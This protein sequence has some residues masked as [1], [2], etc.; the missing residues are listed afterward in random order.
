MSETLGRIAGFEFVGL[1][2][3]AMWTAG[4]VAALLIVVCYF[5][6]SHAGRADR[7]GVAARVALILVGA[8]AAFLAIEAWSRLDLRSERRELDARA[9]ELFMR[10]ATPG[11]AFACLDP[12]VGDVVESACEKAV[13]QSPEATAA[14]LS[15]VAAELTLLA[16]FTVYARKVG[17][18]PPLALGNLRRSIEGDRFGLVARVLAVRDGCTPGNC[19]AFAMLTDPGRIAV[20]LAGRSYD[21]YVER[22]AAAWPAGAKSPVVAATGAGEGDAPPPAAST[23]RSGL[24]F[25]SA[26]SIPPVTIM[27]AEPPLP[28]ETTGSTPPSTP[29]SAAPKQAPARRPAASA[30]APANSGNAQ[31]SRP[32]I[33]LNAAGR[34]SPPASAPQ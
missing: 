10:A 26:A 18:D 24:F 11:S 20:N 22:H 28:P 3:L 12:L 15:Y 4:V 14:A 34:T 19:P 31:P 32:P 13:F 7:I 2:S 6:F 16:D 33:D 8:V 17:S 27:N 9:Q 21:L 30:G 5:S 29:P 23:P 1:P 25:P